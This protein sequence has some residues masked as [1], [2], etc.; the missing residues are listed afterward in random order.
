MSNEVADQFDESLL[1]FWS[2][3]VVA[4]N[5]PIKDPK[6]GL[7]I[8]KILVTPHEKLPFLDGQIKSNPTVITST[9]VDSTGSTYQAQATA[10]NTVVADWW[11]GSNT[12]Q[13]TPPDVRR[14]EQVR[15]MRYGDTDDYWWETC[16]QDDHLR[17]LET[18]IHS[19]SGTAD[20]SVDGTLPENSYN[21]CWSTHDGRITLTTSQ[22]NGEACT[23]TFD[24]NTKTGAFVINDSEGNQFE[25]NSMQQI[26]L[27]INKYKTAFTINQQNIAM[28]A[29]QGSIDLNAQQNITM[30]A[31]KDLT[32]TAGG[33]ISMVAKGNLA[34][35][36]VNVNITG[37][38]TVKGDTSI[39]GN[40]TVQ[41]GKQANFGGDCTFTGAVT[42][43]QPITANGITSNQPITAPN[44]K[45][46]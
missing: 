16:G 29:P 40:L 46:N 30:E 12:G 45:Y 19:I 34:A 33:N 41:N 43:Q 25:I 20:E 42:F 15:L 11:R 9:G 35:Q 39:N 28:A 38:T 2:M 24:V 3:G 1:K 7:P 31:G 17:K 27:M 23:Y 8:T 18:R 44:L 10:D 22:A 26:F 21:F 32:V 13:R 6:T 14:G 36:G 5:K 4:E 37:E